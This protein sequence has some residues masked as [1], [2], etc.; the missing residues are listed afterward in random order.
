M[1]WIT[2]RARAQRDAVARIERAGGIVVYDWQIKKNGDLALGTDP[3]Y[4]KWL[5]ECVGRDY[6]SAPVAVYFTKRQATDG[7]MTYV[8]RLSRLR[9][10]NLFGSPVTDAGIL[11]LA[12][13][14]DLEELQLGK[15]QISSSGLSVL[16][17]MPQLRSL[18]LLLVRVKDEDLIH[19]RK[20][21][22]LQY[23]SLSDT[24]LTNAGLASLTQLKSLQVVAI[25]NSSGITHT[26]VAKLKRSM[27]KLKIVRDGVLY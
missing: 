3:P 19:F 12:G 1:S 22:H 5:E 27:P 20:L 23:L 18:E 11:Q 15:T 14:A 6:F 26:G 4:P 9:C 25:A 10:L 2:V 13:L 16:R 17:S 21:K 8:A 7:D 24:E